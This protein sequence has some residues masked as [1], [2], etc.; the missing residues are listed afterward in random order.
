MLAHPFAAMLVPSQVLHGPHLDRARDAYLS[1][2]AD[3]APATQLAEELELAC[4]VARIARTLT[5][6]RALRSAREQG[7]PVDPPY[8][9]L[10]AL[11]EVRS[12]I[13][14]RRGVRPLGAPKFSRAAGTDPLGAPK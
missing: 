12:F 8:E 11:L 14:P 4:R 5:W 10:T 2:F 1:A 7:E 9:E 13:S 3:L 6:E